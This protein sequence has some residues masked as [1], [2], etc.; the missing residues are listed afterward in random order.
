MSVGKGTI[1]TEINDVKEEKDVDKR[2]D[3][4]VEEFHEHGLGCGNKIATLTKEMHPNAIAIIPLYRSCIVIEQSDDEKKDGICILHGYADPHWLGG[5]ITIEDLQRKDFHARFIVQGRREGP[6]IYL[7]N[8][9]KDPD[10]KSPEDGH[11]K[12]IGDTEK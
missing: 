6:G 11:I 10:D 2:V 3:K 4:F 5:E 12:D 8:T 7:E 1:I 9:D